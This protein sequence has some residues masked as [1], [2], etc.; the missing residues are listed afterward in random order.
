ML[1]SRK[2]EQGREGDLRVS[3]HNSGRGA[4]GIKWARKVEILKHPELAFNFCA[5]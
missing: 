4:L 3:F 1:S 2:G 5:K